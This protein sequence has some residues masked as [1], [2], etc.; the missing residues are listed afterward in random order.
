MIEI[1]AALDRA[2]KKA[3]ELANTAIIFTS[4]NGMLYGEHQIQRGNVVPYEP[5]ARVPLRSGLRATCTATSDQAPNVDAAL[6]V[7]NTV[8]PDEDGDCTPLHWNQGSRSGPA[9]GHFCR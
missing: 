1:V 4:D 8:V 5:S 9:S 6:Y 3:G 7:E 2:L